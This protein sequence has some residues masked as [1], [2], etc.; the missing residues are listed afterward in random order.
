MRELEPVTRRDYDDAVDLPRGLRFPKL[1]PQQRAMLFERFR[2]R[3]PKVKGPW[4]R[5]T[6]GARHYFTT[7]KDQHPDRLYVMG[8]GHGGPHRMITTAIALSLA[9]LLIA[10]WMC[11]D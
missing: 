10:T 2:A 4:Y 9:S 5:G 7:Y 1:L 6:D 3:W 11:H 8:H